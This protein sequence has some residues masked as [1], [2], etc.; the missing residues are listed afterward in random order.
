M[1]TVVHES[2]DRYAVRVRGHKLVADQPI[3]AGGGNTGPTPT[4]MFVAGLAACVA[5]YAGRFLGRHIGPSVPF[6]VTCSYEMSTDRP[7]RVTSVML[8]VEL[9]AALAPDV[10]DAVLR[11]AEHC[12]VHNSLRL[13][14]AVHISVRDAALAASTS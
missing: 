6:S 1:I 9:P 7:A 4:E 3:A 8:T 5:F 13:P 11:A 14:P 12:T 2:G 10:R